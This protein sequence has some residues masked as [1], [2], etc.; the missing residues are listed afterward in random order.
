MSDLG[1][2]WHRQSASSPEHQR[3][4]PPQ[5]LDIRRQGSSPARNTRTDS[6]SAAVLLERARRQH[7]V[8]QETTHRRRE[9]LNFDLRRVEEAERAER[10]ATAA[11]TRTEWVAGQSARAGDSVAA[12]TS[13]PPARVQHVHSRSERLR[14]GAFLDG[15]VS[16]MAS[17]A[18]VE[19]SAEQRTAVVAKASAL[20]TSVRRTSFYSPEPLSVR[21]AWSNMDHSSWLSQQKAAPT[22]DLVTALRMAHDEAQAPV[23]WP[24]P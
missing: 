5:S 12:A 3:L 4:A 18:R 21:Q 6:P 24:T 14:D 7:T 1:A 9:R 16:Y 20:L 19:F 23:L 8:A 11:M 15:S 2:H 17:S 22:L 13:P 10:E